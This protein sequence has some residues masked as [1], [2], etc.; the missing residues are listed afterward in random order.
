MKDE[1]VSQKRKGRSRKIW[2]AIILLL[3]SLIAFVSFFL[4]YNNLYFSPSNIYDIS[5]YDNDGNLI[6]SERNYLRD[7]EKDGLVLLF[8]PITEIL[9]ESTTIPDTIER[10]NRFHAVVKYMNTIKEYDFYFSVDD[11][12]GYCTYNAN[13]YKLAGSDTEKFLSSRFAESL[14]SESVAPVMY[15]ISSDV[16]VPMSVSWNYKTITGQYNSSIGDVV[17]NNVL[18][19]DMSGEL[20]IY[21]DREPDKCLVTVFRNDIPIF[22]GSS[23][24]MSSVTFDRGEM[25]RVELKATWDYKQGISA[26]GN[27]KY[28]FNVTVSDRAEF[29]LTGDTF[30]VD[31]FCGIFCSNVKDASKIRFTSEPPFPITPKFELSRQNAV[32]LLPIVPEAQT[33]EYKITLQYGATIQSFTLTVKQRVGGITLACVA[34]QA[35]VK[36]AFSKETQ[37]EVEALKQLAGERSKGEKLFYGKFL[38]YKDRE[39]GASQYS[40]FGD[41]YVNRSK[42]YY[43]EGHEYRFKKLGG[44]NVLALNGGN[45][46]KTG[47]NAYLGNYVIVSHG[48][49]LATWYAHLST[50]DVVEGDYVVRGESLGKTGT[51]G[52]CTVEN[53]MI[54]VTLDSNFINPNY[55]CGKQFD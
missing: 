44:T 13:S 23:E 1:V 12:V 33:G 28:D 11:V 55:L 25:L 18:T 24:E 26:Y 9:T 17:E 15:S 3:P 47:Y 46:I 34:P 8:S 49:G 53:V 51:S 22:S 14:Y 36:S 37:T 54:F 39:I 38:N 29:H 31:S 45:V 30:A 2:L 7:A 27:I 43:S 16:I 10:S 40:L 50:T 52:L 35:L 32:A 48:C 41:L 21:F 6:D 5:L 4:I 20:G 19:Y 42:G